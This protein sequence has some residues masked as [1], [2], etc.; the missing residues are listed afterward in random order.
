MRKILD[1]DIYKISLM[2][3]FF[4][5][6]V[7]ISG[8]TSKKTIFI[9]EVFILNNNEL[10]KNE[11]KIYYDYEIELINTWEIILILEEDHTYTENIYYI[12]YDYKF[13]ELEEYL[14]WNL[15]EDNKQPM[16]ILSRGT[17]IQTIEHSV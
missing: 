12:I 8:L 6:I 10:S 11:I 5:V 4:F 1:D 9:G 13:V 15:T 3:I 14:Q 2:L 7:I 17:E 16:T